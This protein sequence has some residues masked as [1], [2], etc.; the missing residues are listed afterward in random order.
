MGAR[1][2]KMRHRLCSLEASSQL[3]HIKHKNILYRNNRVR[4][5]TRETEP[6][7][8]VQEVESEDRV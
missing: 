7:R 8:M 6:R 5:G 2:K 3:L 1:K 4:Y